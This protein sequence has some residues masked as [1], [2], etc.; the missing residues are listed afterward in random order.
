MAPQ[1]QTSNSLSSNNN[2][3]PPSPNSPGRT[4]SFHDVIVI[5][6]GLSGLSAAKWLK[7]SRVPDV[8]VLEARARVGGRTLTKNSTETGWVDLGGSY[9]GPTQNHILRMAKDMGVETYIVPFEGNSVHYRKVDIRIR[10]TTQSTPDV[11]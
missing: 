1:H 10:I 6:G 11:R 5:G 3:S 7:D 9:V 2:S 8:L 4:K